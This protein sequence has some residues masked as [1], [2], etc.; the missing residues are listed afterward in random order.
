LELNLLERGAKPVSN[1]THTLNTETQ[2]RREEQ[3]EEGG[4]REGRGKENECCRVDMSHPQRL[5]LSHCG[6][7]FKGHRLEGGGTQV[8]EVH[9][10]RADFEGYS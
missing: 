9:H 2:A 6:S 10:W 7:E 5:G 4:R 1:N 3:G 8:V